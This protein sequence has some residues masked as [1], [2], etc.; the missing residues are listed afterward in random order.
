MEIPVVDRAAIVLGHRI[1]TGAGGVVYEGRM[2]ADSGWLEVAVKEVTVSVAGEEYQAE[3]QK[4]ANTAFI[5]G[6]NTHACTVYGV[7]F[8]E[9]DCWCV[10][11]PCGCI[12]N[13]R[14]SVPSAERLIPIQVC[15]CF[16]NSWRGFR[17]H[18]ECLDAEIC[19]P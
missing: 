11:V 10:I 17:C 2:K 13:G 7:S 12:M 18:N 3:L 19:G 14:T 6:A 1:A 4:V 9:K 8:S 15:E 5:A 16:F